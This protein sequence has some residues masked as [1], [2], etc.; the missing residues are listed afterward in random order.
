MKAGKK[1]LP[2]LIKCSHSKSR[3]V[4]S[5]MC[6]HIKTGF[7]LKVLSTKNLAFAPFFWSDFGTSV[8]FLDFVSSHGAS[9][10]LRVDQLALYNGVV[11]VFS[12]QISFGLKF[13]GWSSRGSFKPSPLF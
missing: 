4:F 9:G 1:C 13:K 12:I 10:F 6:D 3:P 7:K 2:N 8:V 11:L 5:V